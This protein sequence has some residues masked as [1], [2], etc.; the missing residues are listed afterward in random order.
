MP[1]SCDP[2]PIKYAPLTL[3]TPLIAPPADMSATTT[4]LPP[5]TLPDALTFNP[6]LKFVPATSPDATTAP[7]VNILPPRTLPVTLSMPKVPTV[8][9]L[10][11]NTLELSVF[12]VISAAAATETTPVNCDPL[13][14]KNCPAITLPTELIV[15]F[16]TKVP[17]TVAPV[18]VTVIT[19]AIP[20]GFIKIAPLFNMVILLVP[21]EIPD[22][23]PAANN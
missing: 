1:D 5:V 8:V 23:P 16:P 20:C 14:R 9:K 6:A 19:L 17:V 18:A 11:V 15:V 10:L 22:T 2:L 4:T 21:F 7:G 12:P 13:P 3:P